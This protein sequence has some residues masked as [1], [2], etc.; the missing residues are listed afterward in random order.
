MEQTSKPTW[1]LNCTDLGL[2]GGQMMGGG[3]IVLLDSEEEDHFLFIVH[4]LQTKRELM[5]EP[6]T[7]RCVWFPWLPVCRC[8]WGGRKRQ[9]YC[10]RIGAPPDTRMGHGPTAD[11]DQRHSHCSC[12]H[13]HTH[14]HTHTRTHTHTHTH[15]HI[16]KPCLSQLQ[17]VVPQTD[18]SVKGS[19]QL[20][21]YKQTC[22]TETIDWSSVLQLVHWPGK[23]FCH[24]EC[25]KPSAVTLLFIGT[26]LRHT[27]W[28]I[29]PDATVMT[30][31][32]W[33]WLTLRRFTFTI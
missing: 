22:D 7:Y 3:S 26:F 29:C 10:C 32:F 27:V 20:C 31:D 1:T 24:L 6:T 14:T 18:T 19:L 12:T 23:M 33:P 9:D 2:W 17:S 13:T 4:S 25:W 21:Y 30:S 8:C 15:T 28:L 5:C 16:L 11:T